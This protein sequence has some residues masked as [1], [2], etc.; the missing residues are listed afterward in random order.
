MQPPSPLRNHDRNRIKPDVANTEVFAVPAARATCN[1]LGGEVT[2]LFLAAEICIDHQNA[3]AVVDGNCSNVT[4][5]CR[6]AHLPK[7]GRR[8]YS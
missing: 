7:Q 6:Q 2:L 3:R 4:I 1:S 8:V 5:R